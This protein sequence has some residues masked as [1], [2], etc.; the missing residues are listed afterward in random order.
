M[1]EVQ[2][3]PTIFSSYV[4]GGINKLKDKVKLSI[5]DIQV[6]Y[7]WEGC[8]SQGQNWICRGG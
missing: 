3:K 1:P 2:A 7:S 8:D 6:E 4:S 5:Q